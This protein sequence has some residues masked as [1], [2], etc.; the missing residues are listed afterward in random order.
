MD[1]YTFNKIAGWVLGTG[2]I[3]LG[4]REVGNIIFETESPEKPAMAI[5]TAEAAADSKQGGGEAAQPAADTVSIASLLAAADAS[6]G[7]AAVKACKACHSFDKGGPNKVGPNLFDI[8]GGAIAGREGFNYSAALKA[9]QGETWSYQALDAFLTK[10]KAFAPGTKMTF[11]GIKKAKKR[12]DLISYL[13]SL[14]DN[15]AALPEQ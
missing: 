3:V 2:L 6:R 12:A 9:K 13:R 5:E 1:A 4:L 8:V 7:E 15:P 10:P 14:S 11:G